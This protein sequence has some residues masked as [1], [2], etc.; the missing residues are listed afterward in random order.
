MS[1]PNPSKR[2]R[3]SGNILSPITNTLQVDP[4]VCNL[5]RD[6]KHEQLRRQFSISQH[7]VKQ[8]RSQ[9]LNLQQKL[10]QAEEQV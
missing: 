1:S 4:N 10:R 6:D 9:S 3:V 7:E 2:Q 8:L 5:K